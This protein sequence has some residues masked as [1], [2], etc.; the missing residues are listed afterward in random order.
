M[1]EVKNRE[2]VLI[3][4]NDEAE[5]ASAS[6]TNKQIHVNKRSLNFNPN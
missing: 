4:P 3:G 1:F 5:F 6:G 2:S